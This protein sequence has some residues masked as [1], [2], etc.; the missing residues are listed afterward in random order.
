MKCWGMRLHHVKYYKL[1]FLDQHLY[2]FSVE[3]ALRERDGLV[4]IE[5]P[6]KAVAK[7][8]KTLQ[9]GQRVH[10][11]LDPVKVIEK[12]KDRPDDEKNEKASNKRTIVK[13]E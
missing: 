8:F 10:A 6:R 7:Q 3:K 9:T 13:F 12:M 1:H 11:F 2:K 4:H 5:V